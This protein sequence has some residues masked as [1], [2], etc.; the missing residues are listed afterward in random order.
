[1]WQKGIYA[2]V[3]ALLFAFTLLLLPP[4][5]AGAQRGEDVDEVQVVNFPEVQKVEGRV[6]VPL[7]V[8]AAAFVELPETLAVPAAR[9]DT[10]QLVAAGRIDAAGWRHA[11]LSLAGEARGRG[12]GGEVGAL[13]VPDVGFVADAFLDNR[14]LFPLEV[15]AAVGAGARWVESAPAEVALAFPR[16]RVYLYNTSERSVAARLYVHLTQ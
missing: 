7:P 10:A 16:Y 14:V 12:A 13:L 15:E 1:M 6:T 5:R 2:L 8:P 4:E 11:V 9:D 3:L